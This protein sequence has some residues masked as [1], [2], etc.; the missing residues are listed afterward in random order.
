M[1]ASTHAGATANVM[2]IAIAAVLGIAYAAIAL[3]NSAE[4]ST[5]SA[6]VKA[7]LAK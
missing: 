2:A 7:A 6:A 3:G 5:V 1:S 4:M